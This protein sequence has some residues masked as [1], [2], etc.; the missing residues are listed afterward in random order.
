MEISE[1]NK[2]AALA[3][4]SLD[5]SDLADCQTHLGKILDYV[6]LL[7]EVDVTDTDP[8]PHP[9]PRQNVFREDEVR[10]SLPREAAL[11]NACNTDGQFF[12]VPR[13]LE[14]KS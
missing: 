14:E 11:S 6:R 5:E 10:E 3:R 13:I 1:V 7:E 12:L 4:L 2:V 8:L 9:V